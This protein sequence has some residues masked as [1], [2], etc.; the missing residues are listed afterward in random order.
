MYQADTA[1]TV[2]EAIHFRRDGSSFPVEVS[3]KSTY[4]EQG[5]FR[6]HIIRD[7]TKRKENEEKIAWLANHDSLTGIPNRTNF[8]S[9][10]AQEISRT[11]RTGGKF[12][13]M[14]FDIDKF[15]DVND[16]FGHEA[17]DI[18]LCHVATKTQQ[19]VR[20]IDHIG[21]FGG[22]EFVVLQTEVK[23]YEDV[24]SL[25]RRIQEAVSLPVT[26]KGVKISVGVSIGICLF[27]DHAQDINNLLHYADQAMYRA[28]NEKR[29]SF[30]FYSR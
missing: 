9:K 24:K 21:R 18:M 17:G 27:P 7:I 20:T 28:K 16:Q 25:V 6:I 3:V 12:A 4:T 13:V 23:S 15:K 19:T 26:Y 30:I 2:F 10:L 29:G 5:H 14:L 22:D 1:G 8:I 11:K